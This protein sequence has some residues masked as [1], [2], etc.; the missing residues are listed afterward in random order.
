MIL[1]FGFRQVFQKSLGIQIEVIIQIAF[2]Y[3]FF[4][5]LTHVFFEESNNESMD[6][7]ESSAMYFN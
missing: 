2:I 7:Y 6:Y 1:I 4:S 5:K 3:L